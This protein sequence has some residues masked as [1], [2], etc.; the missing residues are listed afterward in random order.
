MSSWPPAEESLN[1]FIERNM[2]PK[3][4][5]RGEGLWAKKE[6]A[7]YWYAIELVVKAAC[8]KEWGAR[9]IIDGAKWELKPFMDDEVKGGVKYIAEQLEGQTV[10]AFG[11]REYLC[12]KG[13]ANVID[14]I[15]QSNPRDKELND[16]CLR[17][18]LAGCKENSNRGAFRATGMRA[19]AKAMAGNALA[20]EVVELLN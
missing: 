2:S 3:G 11:Y 4:K 5:G 17:I 9:F 20:T 16:D 7:L 19:K 8:A 13:F 12:L 10:G 6:E 18:C 15:M 14:E 1:D